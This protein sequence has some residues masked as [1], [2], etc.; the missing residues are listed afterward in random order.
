MKCRG[1]GP[2]QVSNGNRAVRSLCSCDAFFAACFSTACF[3]AR[4]PPAARTRKQRRTGGP[5]SSGSARATTRRSPPRAQRALCGARR[6]LRS[7][8][9]EALWS[10]GGRGCRQ[11]IEESEGRGHWAAQFASEA[12]GRVYAA[13]IHFAFP[14]GAG[15]WQLWLGWAIEVGSCLLLVISKGGWKVGRWNAKSSAVFCAR[16][17][18]SKEVS[19]G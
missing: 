1:R 17:R 7:K 15:N 16:A 9:L 11:E 13:Q 18:V 10:E 3:V 6:A 19:G 2:C 12:R 8:E 14:R 4:P 5:S